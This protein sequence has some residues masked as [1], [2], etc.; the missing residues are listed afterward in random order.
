MKKRKEKQKQ[1]EENKK[2][3]KEREMLEETSTTVTAV[4]PTPTTAVSDNNNDELETVSFDVSELKKEGEE[5]P[6]AGLKEESIE[7]L[8]ANVYEVTLSDPMKITGTTSGY[9]TYSVNVRRVKDGKCYSTR[10][11]YNDFLFLQDALRRQH[12]SC[13]VPSMPEK[14][15]GDKFAPGLI[16][17]RLEG[18]G[19]F[20][21]RVVAHPTLVKDEVLEIFLTGTE[22]EFAAR[23]RSG[24]PPAVVPSTTEEAGGSSSSSMFGSFLSSVGQGLSSFGINIGTTREEETDPWF[25]KQEV[26]LE[27]LEKALSK[28]LLSSYNLANEWRDLAS[29]EA[30]GAAGFLNLSRILADDEPSA[31]SRAT[32]DS[33]SRHTRLAL[34]MA[35]I[36]EHNFHECIKEYIKEIASIKVSDTRKNTHTVHLIT[37][38][39]FF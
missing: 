11:R 4:T 25:A 10:K 3:K 19:L 39:F 23:V 38:F 24:L 18:L 29:I 16:K 21:Q 6:R 36:V 1:K 30:R 34:E 27:R 31:K 8:L 9:V 5:G 26:R 17:E 7:G 37:A 28:L 13:V 14:S 32:S 2:H 12:P 35:D 15:V 20:L 33:L 22:P